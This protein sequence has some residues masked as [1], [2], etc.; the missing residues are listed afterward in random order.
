[1]HVNRQDD[2]RACLS[3]FLFFCLFVCTWCWQLTCSPAPMF[4]HTN[5]AFCHWQLHFCWLNVDNTCQFH[6]QKPKTQVSYQPRDMHFL[7]DDRVW[8][9]NYCMWH[10]NSKRFLIK[11]NRLLVHSQLKHLIQSF[12]YLRIIEKYLHIFCSEN[13]N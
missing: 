11:T 1:M 10:Y 7:S 13:G 3:C 12:K 6:L 2:Y 9:V 4:Y 5:T 8:T